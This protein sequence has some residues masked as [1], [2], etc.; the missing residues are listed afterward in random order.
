MF[1]SYGLET[2]TTCQ[3]NTKRPFIIA[4]EF[5]KK[6]NKPGRKFII[7]DNFHK[8][9]HNREKYPYSHEILVDHINYVNSTHIDMIRLGGRLVFDFDIKYSSISY[10]PNNIKSQIEECINIVLDKYFINV[11]KEKI[12]FIW[13]SCD[14]FEKMSKHLTVKNLYFDNWINFSKFFYQR[15]I[16]IWDIKYNWIKGKDLV[17][18]QIIRKS[19]SLRMVGSSKIGGNILSLDNQT[20]IF[21][22]SLIRIYEKSL[23]KIEQVINLTNLKKKYHQKYL[24]PIKKTLQRRNIITTTEM[25]IDNKIYQKAFKCLD[26]YMPYIF[27]IGKINNNIIHLIRIKPHECLLSEKIHENENAFLILENNV[28]CYN[29]YFGCYRYC[30]ED[31]LIKLGTIDN[32]VHRVSEPIEIII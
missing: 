31:D 20:H 18:E 16:K 21:Q 3:I 27:K 13:S 25:Q 26:K 8:F 28:Y 19:A 23:M 7:F 6:N 22:D 1:E 4:N 5:V 14:N 9:L 10:I 12:Q 15:F 2:I 30:G 24:N 11:D 17:D 32:L 29:I